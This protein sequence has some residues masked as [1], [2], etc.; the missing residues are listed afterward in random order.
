M[1]ALRHLSTAITEDI[2]MARYIRIGQ[3]ANEAEKL[4]LR[5]LRERL[6]DHY[7]VLG[8][9][10]L[11]LPQRRNSLEYDAV[12]I[13][14]YGFY[15]VE[16]KGWTGELKGGD[17]NWVLPWGRIS[18][19]L[20]HLEM[21]TKALANYIMEQVDGTCPECFFEPVLFFPQEAVRLEMPEAMRTNIVRPSELYHH[22][23]DL[24]MVH[25]KGPGPFRSERMQQQV[26]DSITSIA[27]PKETRVFLSYYEV[28]QECSREGRPYREFVGSHRYLPHRAKVR[29]KAYKMDPL[30]TSEELRQSQNRV[31]RDL[32]ALDV[33]MG[34]PYVAQAYDMQ[35]DY[36][37]ETVFY[38]VSEWVSQTTMGDYLA[39]QPGREERLRLAGHLVEA[40]HSIHEA[41]V[42]HRNLHPGAFY[43]TDEGGEVPFKL[44]DFD[45]ARISEEESIADLVNTIG[46][47]GYRA[48]ELS[49]EEADYDEQVDIFALGAMLFEILSGSQ[50][51]DE[52]SSLVQLEETW[53]TK[54][55]AIQDH[56]AREVIGAM[57]A[58]EANRRRAGMERARA[59]RLPWSRE[60]AGW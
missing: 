38:L 40:V 5:M 4:G 55:G 51:F 50:L 10:N 31:V 35:P 25:D 20:S 56:R 1:L 21:K 16:I 24:D 36:G 22:F 19:P 59:A 39:T 13:G 17:R 3:P 60:R 11:R 32:A 54:A 41:G 2:V 15:A 30:L 47:V 49:I 52:A 34:N 48:P 7:K 9:F 44:A 12:V 26:I 37:D 18:N 45:F 42:V 43:I 29:I 28:K 33:L 6:P 14:E 27:S 53:K 23:V 8:N 57:V 58:S 46:T